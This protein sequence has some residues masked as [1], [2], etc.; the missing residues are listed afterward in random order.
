MAMDS[1]LVKVALNNPMIGSLVHACL[2]VVSIPAIFSRLIPHR[3]IITFIGDWKIS[4]SHVFFLWILWKFTV[5]IHSLIVSSLVQD[6]HL[7]SVPP[8]TMILHLLLTLACAPFV[9]LAHSSIF[10]WALFRPANYFVVIKKIWLSL[11]VARK[12]MT[13]RPSPLSPAI[14]IAALSQVTWVLR[15]LS[16]IPIAGVIDNVPHI[17]L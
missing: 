7:G 12:W 3:T 9:Q 8:A 5:E 13:T 14:S 16:T 11:F 4:V 2:Y 15:E 1:W 17:Y 6:L 10:I